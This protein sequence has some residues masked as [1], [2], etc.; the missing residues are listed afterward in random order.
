MKYFVFS[1]AH[2]DYNALMKAVK[3]Y[4]YQPWNSNHTLISC[5]DNFGRAQ[6]GE[7]SKGI[8]DYL[9][10]PIHK[11]PPVCLMGNHELILI[12]ILFKRSISVVDIQNGEHLTLYSFLNMNPEEQELT[13]Y[14]IDCVSRS[15][16]M[17]WLIDRPYFFE[18]PHYLFLHGFLPFDWNETQFITENF[19]NVGKELWD[20]A[21]W[22]QTPTMIERFALEFPGGLKKRI[23][24]GHWHNSDLRI[25]FEPVINYE[26]RHS[27]WR[28]DKLKLIGLDN[29]TVLSH[30]IE[31]LVIED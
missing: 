27:I 25:S 15:N 29:C 23:V 17:D 30:K 4:G 2:G 21:C 6:T 1:D 20:N 28:N 10:S 12:D 11:N 13:A 24:F 19:A 31:M 22:S 14:A 26:T 9:I 3:E 5:G 18:T 16:L 8:Y 7:G